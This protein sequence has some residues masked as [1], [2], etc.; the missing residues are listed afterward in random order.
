M[1]RLST[2]LVT[3]CLSIALGWF[4]ETDPQAAQAP[5]LRRLQGVNE[6]KTWFNAGAGRPRLI[7]LLS[8]T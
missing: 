7:F 2:T 5:S 1:R 8:P 4:V 6:L 3:L